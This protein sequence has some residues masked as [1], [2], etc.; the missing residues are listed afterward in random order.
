VFDSLPVDDDHLEATAMALVEK[1]NKY[2]AKP[3]GVIFY[4]KYPE[5]LTT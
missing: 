5:L 2:Y 3:D 1:A 4:L